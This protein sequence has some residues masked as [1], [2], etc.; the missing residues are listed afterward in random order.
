MA[1]MMDPR[2]TFVGTREYQQAYRRGRA[3][4]DAELGRGRATVYACRSGML[5]EFVDRRTGLPFLW[6]GGCAIGADAFGRMD[7]HNDR[8]E[9]QIMARG[10]PA[11]SLKRWEK[12]IF[13]LKGYCTARPGDMGPHPLSA[14][15]RA[16]KSPDGAFAIRSV[17]RRW[18]NNDG[19]WGDR[20]GIVVGEDA[21]QRPTVEVPFDRGRSELFWGPEGSGFAVIRCRGADRDW[22]MALDVKAV[23]WL[24]FEPGDE[25]PASRVGVGTF[26]P[27]PVSQP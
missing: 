5:T 17:T 13:D 9:E 18:L 14:G 16:W 11:N 2:A 21:S 22:Y 24:R 19:R 8:I 27:G 15:G 12:E 1:R 7:G 26:P 10:L 6:I 20:L 23:Q 3:E 4:A 25:D